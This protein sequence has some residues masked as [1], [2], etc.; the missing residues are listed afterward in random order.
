MVIWPLSSM[1]NPLQSQ[2][3]YSRVSLSGSVALRGLPTL[4]P[5]ALFSGTLRMI[6]SA[7]SSKV[8]GLLGFLASFPPGLSFPPGV[9]T[10]MLLDP[11]LS[12]TALLAHSR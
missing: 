4:V 12:P 10:R 1:V 11:S 3:T 2:R 5:V 6:G 7:V 8:G 9:R